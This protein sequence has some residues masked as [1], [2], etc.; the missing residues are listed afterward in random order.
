[1]IT[2]DITDYINGVEQRGS[3]Y[4]KA[5]QIADNNNNNYVF[6]LITLNVEKIAKNA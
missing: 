1:M 4:L 6:T 2:F 5:R 3:F